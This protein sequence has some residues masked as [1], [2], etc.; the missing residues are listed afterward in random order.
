[1]EFSLADLLKRIKLPTPRRE[2]GG[3]IEAY[4][5]SRGI[6]SVCKV[7]S[8]NNQVL[9]LRTDPGTKQYLQLHKQEALSY[10]K[11]RAAQHFINDFV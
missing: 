6:Q 5:A 2:I 7:S 11:E 8:I 9:Y 1:M 4:L 10:L 3:I